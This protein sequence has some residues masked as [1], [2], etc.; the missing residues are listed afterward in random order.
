MLTML[1]AAAAAATASPP[2]D[3]I[4]Y[5]RQ[6]AA[7]ALAAGWHAEPF[8]SAQGLTIAEFKAQYLG[9]HDAAMDNLG[10]DQA[11][12]S[13]IASNPPVPKSWDWRTS[14][15][16]L[17]SCIG[18]VVNQSPNGTK[19][20]SCWAVSAAETFGDRRCIAIRQQPRSSHA[21]GAYDERLELSALDL[22]ACDRKCEYPIMH[23]DCNMGCLGGF[24]K[25]A[26]EF[27]ASDGIVSAT[28]M[29]YNLSKQMLCPLNQ[30]VPPLDNTHYKTKTHEHVMGHDVIK[31]EL[32]E[33]G[34]VQATFSV[35]EDFMNYK[36]GVYKHVSGRMLGLHAV[37]VIGYGTD[38]SGVDFWEAFN[39]WGPTF[40]VNGTFRIALGECGFE[41]SVFA[42]KPCLP[43]EGY[44]CKI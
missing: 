42:G 43:N 26:W 31:R 2:L 36:S 8:E 35:Y 25:L 14:N 13:A 7:S 6:H 27:F 4:S 24:P 39:S 40:G 41:E 5:V 29:P 18:P 10:H 19:C 30:C 23:R 28:C 15:A 11:Q 9:V 33:N 44:P 1:A 38:D 20:G 34:P 32:V 3:P 12:P 16:S 22:I 37:K 21:R 17:S